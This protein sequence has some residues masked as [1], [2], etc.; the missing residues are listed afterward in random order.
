MFNERLK[1]RYQLEPFTEKDHALLIDWVMDEEFNL[2]WGGPLYQ[3]P[4]TTEQISNHVSR[5]EI[6]PFLFTVAGQVKGYVELCDKQ[7]NQCRLCRVLIASES[8][9]G[10]G[11]GKI[12]IELAIDV[13][14]TKL[15]AEEI[16]LAVFE[17]NFRAI[18]CYRALGFE[19][20]QA[21]Q[22]S[23]VFQGQPWTLLQMKKSCI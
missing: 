19:I 8:E 15:A 9:R 23:R 21:D 2:L 1:S 22:A 3:F 12:M 14:K 7:Q 6:H 13:A 10:H 17:H 16:S 20:Y 4:L 11:Y 5:P 18:S